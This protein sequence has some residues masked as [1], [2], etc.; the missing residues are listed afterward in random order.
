MSI[1]NFS[2]SHQKGFLF[3]FLIFLAGIVG[4]VNYFPHLAIQR[5]LK[6]AGME[7]HPFTMR[8]S[9][10]MANVVGPRIREVL[11]G[12]FF[13]SDVDLYEHK[14]APAF[15][16]MGAESY[17]YPFSFFTDSVSAVVVMTDF[18]FPSIFFL[19]FFGIAYFITGKNLLLSALAALLI[20]LYHPIAIHIPPPNWTFVQI[21]FDTVNPFAF[22]PS[23]YFLTRR[24][25]FIPG[26][27]PLLGTYLFLLC[28]LVKKKRIY[29]ILGGIFLALNAYTYPFHFLYASSVIGILFILLLLQK[30]FKEARRMFFLFGSAAVMLV[31]F[32]LNY[33][34]VTT[35][36]HYAD[37]WS[38][39]GS[40]EGRALNFLHWKRYAWSI[41]L[42]ILVWIWGKKTGNRMV[43]SFLISA[44]L[45]A[46]VVLNLQVI[47]GF[48]IQVDHWL[49]RDIIW[50]FT[51][52]YIA[53]A[54][55]IVSALARRKKEFA[56]FLSAS[57]AMVLLASISYNA[58]RAAT[59]F[60]REEK[61]IFTIPAE[62]KE[63]INWLNENTNPGDVIV[64]PSFV[65]NT[66]IPLYTHNNIF[67]PRA[68]NTVASDDEIIERLFIAYELFN[69]QPEFLRRALL[70]D[71]FALPFYERLVGDSNHD[72]DA[73]ETEAA[74]YLFGLK[75]EHDPDPRDAAKNPRLRMGK[76]KAEEL[77]RRYE[78]FACGADCFSRYR[79]DYI[80]YGPQEK[81]IA[82][83]HFIEHP[84]LRHVAS[85]GNTE[86]YKVKK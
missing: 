85:F 62:Q 31:P 20:S 23:A 72:D 22:D 73:Y 18:I 26:L 50:A 19:L 67:V 69:I 49:N 27:L 47:L 75:Y 35:L 37:I 38:R 28:A 82:R 21:F 70:S 60:A 13:I 56:L 53:M 86:I 77:V 48:S 68:F 83:P 2:A 54:A 39:N 43:A 30:E 84:E 41:A 17:Y 33:L 71:G 64:T 3:A 5:E 11:E 1:R 46:I 55:W 36:P 44:L 61:D 8:G 58:I 6:A 76:V 29:W 74:L 32:A 15:W 52:A 40:E 59:F 34:D 10:D 65:T 79:A 66:Y 78:S 14:D 80:L 25:S 57:L 24:Q 81:K 42:S 4:F 12:N 45:S 9:Y 7:Y 16:P 63:I 51:F